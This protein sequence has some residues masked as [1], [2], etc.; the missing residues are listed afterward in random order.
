MCREA[1]GGRRGRRVPSSARRRERFCD[2]A[3]RLSR[4][5]DPPKCATFR[6]RSVEKKKKKKKQEQEQEQEHEKHPAGSLPEGPLVEILSRVP[7]KSLCRFKCVSKPWLA[8]CSDPDI[9]KRSPKTMQCCGGLVLCKY[10]E[11]RYVEEYEYNLVVCNP[12]TKKWAELPPNPIQLQD[13]DEDEVEEYL[14]FDPAVPSSFVVL[15]HTWDFTEVAIYSS[16]TGRWTTVESGWTD[17][18]PVGLPVFLNGTL[19]LMTPE[20]SI[21]TVDTEGKVWGQIDI[22]GNMRDSSDYP[23]IGQSQGRLYAWCINDNIDVCQLSVWA[24]EDYG[25]AKWALKDTVNISELFGRNC[26]KYVE[27][28]AIHPDC[29]LIF[30]ADRRGKAISYDMD[31]KKVHV[32]GTYKTFVGAVPYVPCFAEWPSD[33]H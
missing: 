23:F 28:L 4:E 33:G 14:C 8:L 1:K 18:A 25:G 30:L 29:D 6:R 5:A 15:T 13:E 32:I 20:Y 24:L 2:A 31:S 17:E 19:H 11:S 7:Y 12:A 22:P 10:W 21:V 27:P 9:R 16:D 3:L 26:C